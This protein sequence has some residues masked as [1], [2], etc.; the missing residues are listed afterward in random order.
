MIVYSPT[1]N[2]HRA[3]AGEFAALDALPEIKYLYSASNT[4]DL[5]LGG[6]C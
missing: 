2:A 4:T 6:V 1:A 3:I 5:R